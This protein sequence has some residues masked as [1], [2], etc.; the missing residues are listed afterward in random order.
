MRRAGG[1]GRSVMG[2]GRSK[3]ERNKVGAKYRRV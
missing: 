3:D 1:I 2:W